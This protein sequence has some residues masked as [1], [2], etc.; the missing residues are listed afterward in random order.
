V[1]DRAVL[2]HAERIEVAVLGPGGARFLQL[3]GVDDLL[4]STAFLHCTERAPA[5]THS[6]LA[7]TIII[8]AS[9]AIPVAKEP[10]GLSRADGK[11][12]DGLTMVPWREGKP[13]SWDVTVVC[14]L[15]EPES[16]IS[17]STTNAGSA[18]EAAATHKVA[19]Y[20]GLERT[21]IFQPVAVEN[22]GMM[23]ASA[24][25]FLA[26]LGQKISA[27]SGDDRETCYLFQRISVLIQRFN[28]TLLHESFA[29]ENRSDD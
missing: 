16:Y 25:G 20:A 21:H 3:F 12:P 13:L 23:N 24:Y 11:R 4:M 22:L 9:A 19:K 8:I 29:D 14:P 27:I 18:A 10:Q 7:A 6:A 28:A 1:V 26:G 17:D 15:A 5:R 2:E